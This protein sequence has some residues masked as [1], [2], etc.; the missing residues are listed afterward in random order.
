MN[1][2]PSVIIAGFQFE[3]REH[4]NDDTISHRRQRTALRGSRMDLLFHKTEIWRTEDAML[5]RGPRV[6]QE[7]TQSRP[8]NMNKVNPL[9]AKPE[10]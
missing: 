7:E 10:V 6:P 9:P 1:E 2:S 4:K 3:R 8:Y 5:G